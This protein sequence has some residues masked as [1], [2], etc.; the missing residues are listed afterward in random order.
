[1]TK[2]K[3]APKKSKD[4]LTDIV[5]A[6][7]TE[8]KP[9]IK[10][11]IEN[12]RADI[13]NDVKE[14]TK[15]NDIPAPKTSLDVNSLIGQLKDGNVDL[16]SLAGMLPGAA[17][18]AAPAA[19]PKDLD[20]SQ[21]MEYLKMQQNNQLVLMLPQ[22]LKLFMPQQNGFMNEMMGRMFAEQMSS[23]AINQRAQSMLVAKLAGSPE[24]IN[25]INQNYNALSKPIDTALDKQAVP[26]GQNPSH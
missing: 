20:P 17:P 9:E 3:T 22:L 19:I 6:V 8:L 15:K 12:L 10:N 24:L 1:M 16:S 5:A 7:V 13:L 14:M 25:Q 21:Q 2:K 4:D 23:V 26:N 11:H 18:A